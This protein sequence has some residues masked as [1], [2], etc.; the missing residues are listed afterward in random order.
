MSTI[1]L[2]G[3]CVQTPVDCDL[4]KNSVMKDS[5]TLTFK[6]TL[7]LYLQGTVIIVL[8][9]STKGIDMILNAIINLVLLV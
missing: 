4:V 6:I 8:L 5:C 3:L 2:L 1:L 7:V 9:L